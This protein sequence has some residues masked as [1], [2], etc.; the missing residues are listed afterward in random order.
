MSWYAGVDL[1]GT[2]IRAVVGNSG[3]EAGSECGVDSERLTAGSNKRATPQTSGVA[4]TGALADALRAA[5]DEAGVDPATLRGVGVASV[6]VVDRERG[7][8]VDP[9]NLP[10]S[11]DWIPVVDPL[12]EVADAPVSLYNDA[13]A[14]L[15]GERRYGD[16]PP[17]AVYLTLST[18]IGAGV[19]VDGRVLSGWHGNAGEVG[20][21]TVDPA[22][23]MPCG[24]GSAGH[25]EAYC[26]GRGIPRY[27]RHLHDGEPT[28]L[29]LDD[30]A[31][32]AAAVFDADGDRFA[33][34]VLDRVARWNAIGVTTLVH[35]YAPSLVSLGGPVA[36]E[37][38]QVVES[39]RERVPDRVMSRTP[40]FERASLGEDA[41]VVGALAAA[42]D[43]D[44]GDTL[45]R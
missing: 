42:V 43:G 13:T 41:V 29:A 23:T 25:W 2:S 3:R 4:V 44:T 18:G 39:L 24:C 21:V 17:N 12:G 27:A 6:G 33:D 22:G 10:A 28:T 16:C 34:R 45:P 30:P 9:A 15:V 37:N 38:P 31:F 20:H 1:G 36:L 35:A 14:G 11:V 8:V 40:A 26:S 7:G 32:D 19:C 5:C